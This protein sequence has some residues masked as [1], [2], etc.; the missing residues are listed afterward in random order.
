VSIRDPWADYS[1]NI[2]ML[3]A[4]D[5]T[6]DGTWDWNMATGEVMFADPGYGAAV[7]AYFPLIALTP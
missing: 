5:G 2:R 7:T 4:L 1:P 6:E 3:L